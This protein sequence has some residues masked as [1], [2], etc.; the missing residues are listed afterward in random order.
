M[1]TP[2]EVLYL[3]IRR[4]EGRVL[5]D[6]QVKQ[7]PYLEPKEW[8]LRAKTFGMFRDYLVK[9]Q[10]K[11]VLEVGCGNGWFAARLAELPGVHVTA[12]DVNEEE[13]AQAKRVFGNINPAFHYADIF[14]QDFPVRFDIIVLNASIQ[15]F[16]DLPKLIHRLRALL[17]DEGEIHVLDSPFYAEDELEH[18]KARSG[19]YYAAIGVPEMAKHY[20]HHSLPAMQKLGAG[21]MYRPFPGVLRRIFAQP[22]FPWLK[23]GKHT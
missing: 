4:K 19:K 15:Y 12:V 7:L 10:V 5:S 17:S 23:L 20:F 11:S 9:K 8:K 13:L 16:S 1:P 6:E 2:F 18:A 14:T 3:S 21:V 22:P